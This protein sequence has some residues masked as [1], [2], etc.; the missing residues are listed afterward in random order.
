MRTTPLDTSKLGISRAAAILGADPYCSP[1][2]AWCEILGLPVEEKPDFVEEAADDGLEFQR[3]VFFRWA[4]RNDIDPMIVTEDASSSPPDMPWL[5]YTPDFVFEYKGPGL[6]ECKLISAY[7]FESEAWGKDGTDEIPDRVRFQVLGQIAAMRHDVAHWRELGID[8]LK[9]E[10]GNVAACEVGFG[11]LRHHA[12]IV[13]YDEGLGEMILDEMARFWRDYVETETPPPIDGSKSCA[14]W[15]DRKHPKSDGVV[16]AADEREAKLAQELILVR[17]EIE[18]L[19]SRKSELDNMLK[20]AIGDH[21]GIKG[22]GFVARWK[23]YAGA[24]KW[25]E[26]AVAL[27]KQIKLSDGDFEAITSQHESKAHRRFELRTGEK[28]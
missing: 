1:V 17:A 11:R 25:K 9:L 4:K 6:V 16:R 10:H 12:Y 7:R 8:P 2:D 14:A 22:D 23:N 28:A 24:T 20:A 18:R 27:A 15:L 26:V 5:R 13:P 19:E 3:P 21:L